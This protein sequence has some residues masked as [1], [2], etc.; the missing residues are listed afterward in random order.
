MLDGVK[1]GRGI[2]VVPSLHNPSLLNTYEAQFEVDYPVRGRILSN[3]RYYQALD[4][5]KGDLDM[6]YQRH[7]NEEF[8]CLLGGYKYE[9][10]FLNDRLM[11]Q[12]SLTNY[13]GDR[14]EGQF[15]NGCLSQG[16]C[17]YQS[18]GMYVGGLHIADRHGLGKMHYS[19]GSSWEGNWNRNQ[20]QGRGTLTQ[21]DGSIQKG[22][23][24]DDRP[25]GIHQYSW[26]NH[27][28]LK[29]IDY[30]N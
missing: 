8:F 13:N 21:A 14:Y 23:W 15:V 10:S 2:L 20:K 29:E 22:V 7:G 1:H 3:T 26:V 9:G 6:N 28:V 19:D 16:T 12:G 27:V 24:N 18:N 11:G 25:V 30:G 17:Y 5:Y 4:I